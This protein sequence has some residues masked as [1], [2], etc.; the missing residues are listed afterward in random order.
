MKQARLIALLNAA[1]ASDNV[2]QKV[3]K[4]L[5][6]RIDT[7]RADWKLLLHTLAT[8]RRK[9]V[10]NRK[11]W[12]VDMVS[13]FETYVE[14]MNRV[15]KKIEE[16]AL[17]HPTIADARREARAKNRER[18]NKGQWPGPT[19][20]A[21][22]Q[23]WVP[24]T[25]RVKMAAAFE[26]VYLKRATIPGMGKGRRMI[27]FLSLSERQ[28]IEKESMRLVRTFNNIRSVY[29]TPNTKTAPTPYRALYLMACSEATREMERRLA[30]YR[31]H[32]ID[33]FDL[34]LPVNWKALLSPSTRERLRLADHNPAEVTP[35]KLGAF[36]LMASEETMSEDELVEHDAEL[37]DNADADAD[38]REY[39]DEGGNDAG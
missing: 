31:D 6:T 19:C 10:S 30:G 22:W 16:A 38:D 32:T 9:V 25:V 2:I 23:T 33:P 39:V 13:T 5:P 34:P 18:A 27:P 20:T 8:D 17:L 4:L 7:P 21:R 28:T 35:H 3:L 15:R 29:A 11:K 12:G 37:A 36:L 14:V 26:E 24:V 1:G